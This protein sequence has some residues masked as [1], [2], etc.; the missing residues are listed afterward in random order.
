MNKIFL[1]AGSTRIA[2]SLENGWCEKVPIKGREEAG[3]IQNKIEYENF[4][5]GAKFNCFPKIKS[6]NK[7]FSSIIVEEC[8]PIDESFLLKYFETGYLKI[9][10]SKIIDKYQTSIAKF[11]GFDIFGFIEE[12]NSQ[13]IKTYGVTDENI[14]KFVD[15]IHDFNSLLDFL[16]MV[17]FILKFAIV[18]VAIEEIPIV[19]NI[20]SFWIENKDKLYIR[21]LWN[22]TQYGINQN[23]DVVVVDAGYT[24]NLANSR[25]FSRVTIDKRN[26]VI[27]KD[28]YTFNGKRCDEIL[29]SNGSP[30]K[31]KFF[32]SKGT[33]YVLS[34]LGQS[35]RIKNAGLADDGLYSWTDKLL[36]VDEKDAIDA[37]NK[38]SEIAQTLTPI[39]IESTFES[40]S[41]LD[42]QQLVKDQ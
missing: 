7:D 29:S 16:N 23:G 26:Y 35:Q 9:V 41:K 1:G 24:K 12:L 20:I 28:L 19:K 27:S 42:I 13:M 38:M 2:Y 39:K 37:M 22:L 15:D 8:S 10:K 4:K 30:I 31:W 34:A 18:R 21:D 11:I 5:L 17:N 33:E 14:L 6:H 25:H 40:G 32:T 3:I 36:F